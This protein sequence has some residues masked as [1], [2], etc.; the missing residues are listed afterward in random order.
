VHDHGPGFDPAFLPHAFERFTRAD[1]A[2]TAG[3][4]G[5]G[6]AIVAT[7]TRRNHGIVAARNHPDGGAEVTIAAGLTVLQQVRRA[8]RARRDIDGV[9]ASHGAV[10][11]C[12]YSSRVYKWVLRWFPAMHR[13]IR[14]PRAE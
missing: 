1:A 6:L 2:R 8:H 14:C 9:Q 10:R 11:R 13:Q 5:L 3:G 4:S 7:L 12:G